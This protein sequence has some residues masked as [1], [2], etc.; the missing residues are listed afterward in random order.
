MYL[1]KG[2][3]MEESRMYEEFEAYQR[4]GSKIVHYSLLLKLN[5]MVTMES[6]ISGEYRR[7]C[8]WERRDDLQIAVI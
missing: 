6:H 8:S 2:R 5:L 4:S 1:K 3:E 7:R